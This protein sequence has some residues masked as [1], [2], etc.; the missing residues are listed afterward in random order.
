[1]CCVHC[2]TTQSEFFVDLGL[3]LEQ[4]FNPVIYGD[5]GF[6]GAILL[7]A[8]HW[9]NLVREGSRQVH[10]FIEANY[11]ET[12]INGSEPAGQI[13]RTVVEDNRPPELDNLESTSVD[14]ELHPDGPDAEFAG[15]FFG[16]Q[17]E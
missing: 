12:E 1:M 17:G 9:E 16:R 5:P 15:F 8:T 2:G 10:L 7:C 4:H 3:N 11:V 13:D 6:Q 14:S